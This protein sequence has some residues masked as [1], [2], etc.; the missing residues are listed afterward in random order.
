MKRCLKMLI[1]I[2]QWDSRWSTDIQKQAQKYT[3]EGVM[4]ILDSTQVRIMICA[5]DANL[6]DF[7]DYLYDFFIE[8]KMQ[9]EELEPFIKEKDY[10]G[11]FR[12]I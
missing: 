2:E 12:V 5:E 4:Q 6:D 8:R 3:I 9:I 7:I 1:R 11:I 10:R